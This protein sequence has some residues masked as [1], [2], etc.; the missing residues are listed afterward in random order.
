MQLAVPTPDHYL[1]L[2]YT[3]GLQDPGEPIQLFNDKLLAGSLSMTSV[4]IGG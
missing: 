2:L 3:L 1:P 4:R